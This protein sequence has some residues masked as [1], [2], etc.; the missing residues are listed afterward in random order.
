MKAG[1]IERGA[2]APMPAH[3]SVVEAT[4]KVARSL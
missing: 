3:S 4:R 1:T 2:H